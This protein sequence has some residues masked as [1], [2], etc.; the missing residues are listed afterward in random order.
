MTQ[1]GQH[2]VLSANN[3]SHR[4]VNNSTTTIPD[5]SDLSSLAA[6]A[7]THEGIVSIKQG[8]PSKHDIQ[9]G[10][11]YSGD[12]NVIQSR[13]VFRSPLYQKRRINCSKDLIQKTLKLG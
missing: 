4:D 10:S 3:A 7:E 6:A 2:I 12:L 8:K 9:R 5:T 1:D 13:P 11:K